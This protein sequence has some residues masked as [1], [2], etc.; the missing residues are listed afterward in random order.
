MGR[1]SLEQC[2]AGDTEPPDRA[3]V[4][5]L[6]Q[7]ADRGVEFSQTVEAPVAQAAEQPSLDDQHRDFDFRLVRPARPCR[8]DRRIIMRRRLGVGPIDL[9][10]VE[11]GLDDGD[12]GVVR[13]QQLGHAADGG[14]G[15]G[16]GS[17]PVAKPLRPACFRHR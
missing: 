11:A 13:H 12:L 10:L 15:P 14:K 6:P 4:V 1:S 3:F 17:D 16:V 5:E 2:P 7:L 8:Q 9:R